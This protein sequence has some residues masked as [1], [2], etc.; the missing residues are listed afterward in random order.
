MKASKTYEMS[1]SSIYNEGMINI[2]KYDKLRQT[3]TEILSFNNYIIISSID[4][5][6]IINMAV[7]NAAI[8]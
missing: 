7:L 2:M 4:I 3:D 8:N 5:I 6:S 1:K